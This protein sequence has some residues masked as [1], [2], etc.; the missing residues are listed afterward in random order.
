MSIKETLKSIGYAVGNVKNK[1]VTYLYPDKPLPVK[2]VSRGMLSLDIQ[3]CI[4]CEL[5]QRICPSNAI[6]M[7]KV[8][9]NAAH[10]KSNARNE[11]PAV[12]FA[13]CIFC[14]LCMQICPTNALHHTH[15]YDISS[16]DKKA[17][18]YDPFKLN[19]VFNE[20]YK[21]LNLKSREEM[22]KPSE[23][24]QNQNV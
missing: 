4:G 17:L 14:G 15:K 13:K 18:F 21:P 9:P 6:T 10:F 19:D 24:Q 8:D 20:E 7:Q 11:A 3:A 1:P 12:D 23:P 5:C 22:E 2:E 16:S